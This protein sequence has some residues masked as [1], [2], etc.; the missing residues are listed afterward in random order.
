MI[1]HPQI[2][3]YSY[4]LVGI[5]FTTLDYFF[6]GGGGVNEVCWPIELTH[7]A[8]NILQPMLKDFEVFPMKIKSILFFAL[9]AEDK[10]LRM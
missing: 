4:F 3:H 5:P 2:G 8:Q 1:T 10:Y 6:G 7:R 9:E